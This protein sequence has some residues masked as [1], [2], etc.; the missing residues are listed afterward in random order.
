MTP[1]CQSL[2][3]GVSYGA[4]CTLTG[5]QSGQK[6]GKG[7]NQGLRSRLLLSGLPAWLGLHGKL[8]EVSQICKMRCPNLWGAARQGL[9]GHRRKMQLFYTILIRQPFAG[10]PEHIAIKIV[11]NATISHKSSQYQ[12]ESE[13]PNKFHLPCLLRLK[14]W[15]LL[16][17]CGN[18]FIWHLS[19]EAAIMNT[20]TYSMVLR[21]YFLLPAKP[22]FLSANAILRFY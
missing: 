11:W 3:P 16:A 7:R 22:H 5:V 10:P 4:A 21:N 14:M 12:H 17:S 8:K 15:A 13:I 1:I 9:P 6:S 2:K 19:W 18:I 20:I